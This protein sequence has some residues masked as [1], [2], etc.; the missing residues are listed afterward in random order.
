MSDFDRSK[1]LQQLEG[2]DWG[3]PN[4]GSHLVT[5]C[6]RLHKVPLCDF[7]VE[8]LRITIGQNIGLEYLVPLAIEKLRENPLAE[9]D[10]YPGDLL[11]NVLSANAAFWRA[12]PELHK[13]LLPVA[14]R[15][16]AIASADEDI[17][18]EVVIESVTTAYEK[19]KRQSRTQA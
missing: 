12:H 7:R 9:G 3:E 5:E 4:F 14:E 6:H 17:C 8:D 2:E 16:L 1:S 10:C 19:F 15:A 18:K 11:S 13:Q